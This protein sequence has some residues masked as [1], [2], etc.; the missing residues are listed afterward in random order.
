MIRDCRLEDGPDIVPLLAQLGYPT[1]PERVPHRINE[2]GAEPGRHLLVADVDHT[3]AGLAALCLIPLIHRDQPLARLVAL[4][5]DDRHR[6][7]GIGHALLDRTEQIAR[8]SSCEER[9]ITSNR[10]RD[11]A[12]RFYRR[13][14][15]EDWCETSARFRK[16]L[17]AG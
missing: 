2:W 6:G 14:G 13:H 16:Q 10:S 11:G 12:H 9:E 3:V 17:H 4:V 15:Y 1:A 8:Q 5:V 7:A